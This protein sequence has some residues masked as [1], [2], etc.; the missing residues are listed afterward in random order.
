MEVQNRMWNKVNPLFHLKL[1]HGIPT[2]PGNEAGNVRDHRASVLRISWNYHVMK[3]RIIFSLAINPTYR[4]SGTWE[5]LALKL[6]LFKLEK[7]PRSFDPHMLRIDEK[8]QTI[9]FKI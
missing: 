7:M 2:L 6:S 3:T 9:Y 8:D 1:L 4:W 5:V